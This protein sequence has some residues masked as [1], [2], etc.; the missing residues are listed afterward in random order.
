MSEVTAVPLRP[1]AKGSLLK[2]WIGVAAILFAGIA[3][4]WCTTANQVIMA[5]SP[6]EFLAS[7][8]K[9]GGVIQTPSGLQY[10]VLEDGTGPKPTINDAVLVNYTGELLSGKVFDSTKVDGEDKSRPLPV[11]GLIAGWTEG[12]QLM[13][14]GAKY[15]FWIPPS[16]AYGET[17]AGG[18]A[19]PPNAVLAFDVELVDILS[20]PMGMMP[21]GHGAM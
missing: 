11:A 21:P 13:N 6:D 14:K 5:M 4:A 1:I 8:A 10:K 7:N 20:S 17:G 9:K 16:L 3:L 18:G 19:I 15:R 2:L 12:M